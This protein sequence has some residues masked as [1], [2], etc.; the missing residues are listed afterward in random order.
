M[1]FLIIGLGS[2]GKRRIRNL[3]SLGKTAIYG[4]DISEEK[5]KESEEKYQIKTFTNLSDA[6][7]QNP[8]AIIISTSPEAHYQYADLAIK[9]N[10]PF[11]TELNLISEGL[12]EI[13][14]RGEQ[15]NI[16]MASSYDMR[17]IES[18]KKIKE[19]IND[20]KIGKVTSF[21][22][23]VGQYLPDWHPWED[24][25]KFFGAKKET[26]ACIELIPGEINWLQWIFGDIESV[27]SLNGKFSNLEIDAPDTYQ[28]ILKFKKG[29]L[30]HYLVDIVS[31]YPYR[32]IKI[33]GTEGT[34]LWD[35][36]KKIVKLFTAK[37]KLWKE[38]RESDGKIEEGYLHKEEPYIEEIRNFISALEKNK[39]YPYL[40]SQELENLKVLDAIKT[41]INNK[42]EIKL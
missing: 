32:E 24:Y 6:F 38:F 1:K 35:H 30:G 25:R 14:V 31:R 39:K 11:F 9:K 13:V 33:I 41:S 18:I 28:I 27:T 20:N 26:N 40:L 22:Y 15:K 17:N 7:S 37:D 5:R 2:M 29:L 12:K 4:F 3:Q 21:S 23:H 19:L 16:I 34:I 36:N 42:K 10:I 8:D